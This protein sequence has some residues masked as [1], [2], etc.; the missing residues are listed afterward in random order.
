ML[1]PHY[2]SIHSPL[3]EVA[4]WTDISNNLSCFGTHL[5]SPPPSGQ[6]FGASHVKDMPISDWKNLKVSDQHGLG[7]VFETR[8][9]DVLY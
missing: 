7:Q 8:D 6:V 9:I 4:S 2:A 1:L 5:L 3:G